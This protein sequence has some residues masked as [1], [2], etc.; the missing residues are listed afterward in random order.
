MHIYL[1]HQK[2]GAIA[3][4][5][6]FSSFKQVDTCLKISTDLKKCWPRL[7]WLSMY[8]IG[9]LVGL[10]SFFAYLWVVWDAF[11]H[12]FVAG[13]IYHPVE[14]DCFE[15][16]LPQQLIEWLNLSEVSKCEPRLTEKGEKIVVLVVLQWTVLLLHDVVFVIKLGMWDI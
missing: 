7:Q 15:M 4:R 13:Y 8:W 12:T 16:F 5:Y 11:P 2:F 9:G 3:T 6:F 10:T 14:D 1:P